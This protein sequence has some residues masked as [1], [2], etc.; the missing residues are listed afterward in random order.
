[1]PDGMQAE[2][3][4]EDKDMDDFRNFNGI[5]DEIAADLPPELAT[6]IRKV[7]SKHGKNG[8]FPDQQEVMR[9][10]PWLAD[11]LLR[12]MRK[13]D[14]DGILPDINPNSMPGWLPRY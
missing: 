12:E 14:A 5:L 9:K 3:C 13:A 2:N 7:F 10:D 6:L 1:M 8:P 11:Q 4:N